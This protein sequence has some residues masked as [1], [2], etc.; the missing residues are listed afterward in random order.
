MSTALFHHADFALHDSGPRHPE[1]AARMSAILEKLRAENLLETLQQPQFSAATEDDLARAHSREHIAHIRDLAHSGG[2]QI[3][4]DTRVGEVSYD[5]A[6]SACGAA[7]AA[8]ARVL[9]GECDNAFV[10]AR[11]PGHHAESGRAMGFCLFNTVAVAARYALEVGSLQR[12]AILDFDVHHGNGTQQIFYDDA[13]VFFAS[14][15]Q[16]PHYPGTGA[17]SETGAGA[18]LGTARNVPLPVGCGDAEYEAAWR[19]LEAPLRDFA[20]Q[21][22]FI[23]AGFDAHGRDP[24]GGMNVTENGF[25]TMAKIAIQWAQKCAAAKSFSCWKAATI[26]RGLGESVAAVIK[27]MAC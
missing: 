8:T 11:P 10:V 13:R 3:D 7:I 22:I 6:R 25:A 24:L 26:C 27:E 12:V 21:M 19:T 18:A 1:R 14:L 15:H 16:A 2:G 20:P 5:V 23:S 9:A 17:A 4:G